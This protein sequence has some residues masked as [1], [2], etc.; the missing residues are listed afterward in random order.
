MPVVSKLALS[1]TVGLAWLAS[2]ALLYARFEAAARRAATV[3][4]LGI[5]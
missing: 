1:L 4:A 5:S 2:G 3:D